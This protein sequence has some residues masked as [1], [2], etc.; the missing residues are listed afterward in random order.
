MVQID[1]KV[2]GLEE[3]LTVLLVK[4][5]LVLRVQGILCFHF[6]RPRAAVLSD[7]SSNV[8]CFIII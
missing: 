3:H 4:A 6:Q 1:N 7:A 8:S 2:E 5:R